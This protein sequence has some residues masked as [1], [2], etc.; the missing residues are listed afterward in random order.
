MQISC[1]DIALAL[2]GAETPVFAALNVDLKGP[3]F[4]AL[5]GPSGVGKTTLAR[6]LIGQVRPDA[7]RIAIEGCPRRLYTYNL[8]RLPGWSSVGR[9]LE[10]I[11]P[12]TQRTRCAELAVDFGI[13]PVLGQHFARL[14]L[15]QKNRVNL[16][17]YLV[18][19]FDLLIMDES[20]ANVDERT[21]EQIIL[22]IKSLFP[23]PFFFVHLPQRHRSGAFLSAGPGDPGRPS[24]SPGS[25]GAG[26][27]RRRRGGRL[28]GPGKNHAGDHE[29]HLKP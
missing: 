6:M 3:G 9:H 27:G 19:E 24:P 10:K 25:D 12:P 20:L 7:G 13:E 5:F 28:P 1:D 16:I 15:G 29:R 2:V 18:Q 22:K 17:R 23:V 14:S 8:E 11:T 4:H 26:P 21:R